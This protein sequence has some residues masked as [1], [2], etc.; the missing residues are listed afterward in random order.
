MRTNHH[1]FRVGLVLT[2]LLLFFSLGKATVSHATTDH[3]TNKSVIT[4]YNDSEKEN[5]GNT[6]GNHLPQTSELR[7]MSFSF[8]G[9]LLVITVIATFILVKRREGK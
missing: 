2:C 7:T 9:A 1:R 8:L 5:G 4:L 3:T 6:T